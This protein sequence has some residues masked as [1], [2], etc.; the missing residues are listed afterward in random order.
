MSECGRIHRQMLRLTYICNI[1][2][3]VEAVFGIALL[4][5]G[6]YACECVQNSLADNIQT[7]DASSTSFTMCLC[8]R[9]FEV[10]HLA[11]VRWHN[12]H[13]VDIK[14]TIFLIFE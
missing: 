14:T 1:V 4:F 10:L 5:H 12:K 6:L 3:T 8:M 9:A 7:V 2:Y 11:F 13:F